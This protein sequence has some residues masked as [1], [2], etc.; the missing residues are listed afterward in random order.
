METSTEAYLE[1]SRTSTMELLCNSHSKAFSKLKPLLKRS[2]VFNAP[3]IS[4]YQTFLPIQKML[5]NNSAIIV[6][7]NKNI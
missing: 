4:T 5:Y 6:A 3:Q 7:Y 2:K 1:P